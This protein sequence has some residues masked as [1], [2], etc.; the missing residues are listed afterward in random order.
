[1][2]ISVDGIEILALAETQKKVIKDYVKSEIFEEDMKRRIRWVINEIYNES[3]KRLKSRWDSKL[4][5]N[6]I[7][8]LPIS[9]DAYA[10]LVFSQPNYKDRTARD[11][12]T[13]GE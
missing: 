9:K 7:K 4:E 12:E 1:M 3:F 13:K 8:S 6:G 2:K 11:A 5:S 10:E